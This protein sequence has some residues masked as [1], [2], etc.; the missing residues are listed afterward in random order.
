MLLD[1]IQVC[2]NRGEKSEPR[3]TVSS[4]S[5]W[6]DAAAAAAAH[7][8]AASP[9]GGRGGGDSDGEE[10][11]GGRGGRESGAAFCSLPFVGVVP[12]KKTRD[13]LQIKTKKTKRHT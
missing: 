9:P 4:A 10:G 8:A 11:A 2:R 5:P 13:S 6:S 12:R 1:L 7:S 3:P